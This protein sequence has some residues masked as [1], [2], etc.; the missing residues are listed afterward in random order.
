MKYLK[1]FF[2]MFSFINLADIFN[3]TLKTVLPLVHLRSLE[4]SSH[5]TTH[6]TD[7]DVPVENAIIVYI[8][9]IT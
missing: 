3:S 8:I 9:N 2:P 7:S 1:Y 4:M 5:K 6:F